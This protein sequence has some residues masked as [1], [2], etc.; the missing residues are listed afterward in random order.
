MLA[1]DV[2]ACR[3]GAGSA[4]CVAGSVLAGCGSKELAVSIS[5]S[6]LTITEE[7]QVTTYGVRRLFVV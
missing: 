3:E 1:A 5:I 4:D 2:W 7:R 6:V